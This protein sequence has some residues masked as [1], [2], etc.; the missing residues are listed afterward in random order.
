[1]HG[2]SSPCG[3][4]AEQ[5]PARPGASLRCYCLMQCTQCAGSLPRRASD[6]QPQSR[7]VPSLFLPSVK[8]KPLRTKHHNPG[9]RFPG[10]SPCLVLRLVPSL[11]LAP[12]SPSVR[13]VS[14]HPGGSSSTFPPESR[15][16]FRK[17]AHFIS[18]SAQRGKLRQ[19]KGRALPMG[20]RW[21]RG[22]VRTRTQEPWLTCYKHNPL[23]LSNT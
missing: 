16:H 21:G 15:N 11:A 14:S 22:R 7:A 19:A 2:L 10:Q 18:S 5:W 9:D 6:L 13:A 23:C 12:V 8:A 17:G 1:M 20:T 4:R 3:T